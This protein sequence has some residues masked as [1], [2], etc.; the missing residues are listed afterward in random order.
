MLALN[1]F[2]RVRPI[3]FALGYAI[4]QVRRDCLTTTHV[5]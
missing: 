2:R 1:L 3:R 4:V 5:D